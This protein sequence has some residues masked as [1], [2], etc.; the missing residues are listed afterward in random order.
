MSIKDLSGNNSSNS[1]TA[2]VNGSYALSNI[3]IL[4]NLD[5]A[6]EFINKDDFVPIVNENKIV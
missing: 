6:P 4:C 5:T 1:P 2:Y 3:T